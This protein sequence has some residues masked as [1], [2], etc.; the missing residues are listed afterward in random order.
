MRKNDDKQNGLKC[1]VVIYDEMIQ[2][3][4]LTMMK[5]KEQM[6]QKQQK[7]KK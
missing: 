6:E 2:F 7:I 5:I 1:D 4:D 3:E